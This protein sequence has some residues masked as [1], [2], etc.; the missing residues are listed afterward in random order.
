MIVFGSV[1]RA[2]LGTSAT[3]VATNIAKVVTDPALPEVL[4]LIMQI[5]DTIPAAAP[6]SIVVGPASPGVGLS[7][8]VVPLEAIL[9]ARKNPWVVPVGVAAL[10]GLPILLGFVMGRAS[11]RRTP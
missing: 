4:S 5:K 9:Y 11:V 8:A 6:G 3:S 1:G 2:P 7:R 10:F